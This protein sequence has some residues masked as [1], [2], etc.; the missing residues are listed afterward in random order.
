[1]EFRTE[2]S[3]GVGHLQ[4]R[5]VTRLESIPQL[6]DDEL[7]QL[8][9]VT[10]EYRFRSNSYYLGLID[11]SDPADPIRRLIIPARSELRPGGLA[12]P[13]AESAVTVGKGIQHKYRSTALILLTDTCAGLCRFCFR[14]RLFFSDNEEACPD[15]GEA[16][17]YI[18]SQPAIDNVLITGGDPLILSTTNLRSVLRELREIEHVKAIRIG[19]K[20]PAYNPFRIIN[21][22]ELIGALSEYSLPDRRIYIMCHFDHPKELTEDSRQAVELLQQA[23]TI[24]LNQNPIAKGISDDPAVMQELWNELMYLGVAQYYVFQMRPAIGNEDFRVPIVESFFKVEEAKRRC[25]GIA[26]RVR[27]VMSHASGKIEILG[28]DKRFIFM[29]YHRAKHAADEQRFM[30]FRRDDEAY[31]LD[32]LEP[33]RQSSQAS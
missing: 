16:Y 12:D 5:Y 4:P 9:R 15:L 33:A 14:K 25:S 26:K 30:I 27:F 28:V 6:S 21:D 24:C 10:A 18:R 8:R 3:S 29:K 31:W 1:M 20:I 32:D 11:W 17:A 2:S 7:T 13:S 22:P 23:G 19:T